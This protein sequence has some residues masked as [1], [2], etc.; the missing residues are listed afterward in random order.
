MAVAPPTTAAEA[1][2]LKAKGNEHLKAGRLAEA[3]ECYTQALTSCDPAD[4]AAL[5]CNRALAELKLG[6][7]AQCVEDCDAAIQKQPQYGKAFFRR[8]QAREALDKLPEAFKDIHELLRIEP[9]NKEA[10]AYAVKLKRAMEMKAQLG[11]L[12]TPTLA[13]EKLL[14]PKSSDED[15]LQAVGKLSRCAEDKTRAPELLHAGC[16]APILALLP[17]PD[18]VT[19][20]ASLQMPLVGLC[21]EVL[22]RMAQSDDVS[23]LRAIAATDAAGSSSGGK[24]GATGAKIVAIAKA[25]ATAKPPAAVEGEAAAEAEEDGPAIVDITPAEG[26]A[27]AA[28]TT[29]EAASASDD[30][31]QSAKNLLITAGKCISLAASLAGCR[32]AMGDQTAQGALLLAV[33]PFAKEGADDKIKMSG[34]DAVLRVADRDPEACRGVLPQLIAALAWQLGD[35][36]SSRHRVALA[37]LHKLLMPKPSEVDPK[38]EDEDHNKGVYAACEAALSK[39][40]RSSSAAWEEHV[41]AVHGVTAVLE[42]NKTV[43]A[44]LLRQESIFWALAEVAE[45]ED[46]ELTQSL[47]EIYAHAANDVQHFRE[48]A[49][50]E[51]IKHLRGMLKSTQP[52]IRA[53]ACV[54]L[55]KVCL[56]HHDHRVAINPTGKLLQATLGLL[57]AKVAPSVHRWAVEALM[58]LTIMPDVKQHLVDNKLSF[59]SLTSLAD[60]VSKEE[61]KSTLHYSLVSAL[62]Q[63][64]CPKEKTDEQKRLEQEMDEKQIEQMRQMANPGAQTATEKRDDPEV[65]N[66]LAAQLAK[67]DATLVVSELVA[68]APEGARGVMDSAARVLLAMSMCADVRGKMVQQGGFKALLSLVLSEEKPTR[69]SAAWALS[70]IAIS[71]NPALYPRRTGSGPE[72][73]VKPM[74]QLVDEADNE[75]QQFEACMGLCNLATVPELRARMVQ[76]QGWRS[77]TMALT[78]EN[79]MVQRAAIEAMSNMVAEDEIVEKFLSADSQDVKIF[80]GFAG[81]DDEK[82]QIAA[83]GALAT[84]AEIPEC[85]E[86]IL[87]AKGGIDAFVELAI[88]ATEPAL[89]HR[90]AV[91]LKHFVCNC[92]DLVV[93]E[94]DSDA[95]PPDHAL[96]TLGALTVLSKSPIAPVKQAALTAIVEL[97]KR[98][99]DVALP[100]PDLI[101][102]VVDGMKEEAAR[103]EAERLAEEAEAEAEEAARKEAGDLPAVAEGDED[104]DV[105]EDLGEVV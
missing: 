78:C 30:A 95:P 34:L 53:R 93:G 84:L 37:T 22:E 89:L 19:D 75:L 11:D 74:L 54:A 97:Q 45:M 42:V 51:P 8:A 43:G 81:S 38:S 82:A 87:K 96:P 16:V 7:H 79:P 71:I 92:M 12:S 73:M 4:A 90:A 58:Y 76:C 32:G 14:N 50:E 27:A 61:G 99:P 66:A 31:A 100:H 98:R 49:G 2:A 56:L 20:A 72:G 15:K 65:M 105:D 62:R 5:H 60:S 80:I 101:Q 21:V 26:A 63:M 3:S 9:S 1:V 69:M 23:V 94:K 55:A 57:E 36:E 40:L 28:A 13:V 103:R 10:Q 77:L 6:K 88:V 91:A 29:G 18:D 104:A 59:G 67:D 41:A 85:S 70:R 24:L 46:D 83:S 68:G 102:K 33:L 52:K 35:E 17:A 25:A 39:T 44:W 86:A 47:A 64:C 48:K